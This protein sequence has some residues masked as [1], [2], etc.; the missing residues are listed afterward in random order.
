MSVARAARSL[1]R[2]LQQRD[3]RVVFAESCTGGLVSGA[4]TQIPGISQFLCGSMVTYRDD[5]KHAWLGVSRRLLREKSAVSLEVAERMARGVLQATPEATLALSVTGHLG[6]QA[7]PELDG[8][9]F[10]GLALRSGRS[11]HTAVQRH[12]FAPAFN[13]SQ[14]QR[15][16]VEAVL[17]AACHF[18]MRE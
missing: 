8:L 11:T 4:L 1:A 10:I 12:T 17:Q 6:P 16:A 13:R 5:S 9:V 18:L 15:L 7:P 2:L 14:R 3:C